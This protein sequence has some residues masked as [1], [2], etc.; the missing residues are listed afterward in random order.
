M[1]FLLYI[2]ILVLLYILAL[3]YIHVKHG[4]RTIEPVLAE[5]FF[6]M[7]VPSDNATYHCLQF[8]KLKC[9]SHL[10]NFIKLP[11]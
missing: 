3:Q 11:K 10:S 7:H 4:L 1:P 9:M 8:Q 5:C 6:Q 2:C